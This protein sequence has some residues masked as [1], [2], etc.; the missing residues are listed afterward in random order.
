MVVGLADSCD[1]GDDIPDLSFVDMEKSGDFIGLGGKAD[2]ITINLGSLSTSGVA[3]SMT[4]G[5]KIRGKCIT[6]TVFSL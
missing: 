4:D 2:K 3:E 6:S 1:F 5:Q